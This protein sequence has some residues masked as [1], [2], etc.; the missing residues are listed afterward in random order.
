MIGD[1][2]M[3]D[4]INTRLGDPYDRNLNY[5]VGANVQTAD[6]PNEIGELVM[7][8]PPPLSAYYLASDTE[9]NPALFRYPLPTL[10]PGQGSM[11][12]NVAGR[13]PAATRDY[14]AVQQLA[15][16]D[17]ERGRRASSAMLRAINRNNAEAWKRHGW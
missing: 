15:N 11:G 10:D 14:A 1:Q 4:P 7:R 8:L 9:G 17:R 16:A 13:M 12:N 5:N 6:P 2:A 3:P